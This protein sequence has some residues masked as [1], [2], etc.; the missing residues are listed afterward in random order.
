MVADNAPVPDQRPASDPDWA[1]WLVGGVV[2]TTLF[3]VVAS[4]L[5]VAV[6]LPGLFPVVLGA[7]AGWGLGR[8]A[9]NR[10]LMKPAVVGLLAGVF[11][12]EGEMLLAIESHRSRISSLRI[13]PDP[14]TESMR[15]YVDE[16]RT[17][18]DAE[19]REF[20][21]TLKNRLEADDQQRQRMLSFAGHLSQ[22]IPRQWGRWADPWPQLY[23][24]LEVLLG[25][26]LGSLVAFRIVRPNPPATAPMP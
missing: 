4:H 25:C 15:Q 2:G 13:R 3:F 12:L 21:Q 16:K 7:I 23:F 8:W 22:R 1:G 9:A 19:S 11:I 20:R 24:G 6:R 10:G 26:G 18:D 5:P 14:I 17:D